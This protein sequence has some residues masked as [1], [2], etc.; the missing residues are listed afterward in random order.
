MKWV[1]AIFFGSIVFVS[2][3]GLVESSVTNI[4]GWDLSACIGGGF[5]VCWEL[6]SDNSDQI[7]GDFDGE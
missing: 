4:Q 3:C 1:K 6:F 5:D 2:G 7:L